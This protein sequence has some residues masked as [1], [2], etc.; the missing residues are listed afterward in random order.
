MRNPFAVPEV[1][2]ARLVLPDGWTAVPPQRSV[3]V[4]PQGAAVVTFRLCPAPVLVKRAPFG[5]ELTVGGFAFGQQAE[6]LVS[7]E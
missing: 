1:A 5:V 2:L 4:A 7:V 6:A 3:K